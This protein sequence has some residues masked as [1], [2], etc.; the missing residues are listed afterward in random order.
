MVPRPRQRPARSDGVP[1]I[2]HAAERA[3]QKRHGQGRRRD[4]AQ[5]V[6]IAGRQAQVGLR[7][8]GGGGPRGHA[9][10]M[11]LPDRLRRRVVMADG[12]GIEKRGDRA[13][14]HRPV[15]PVQ[16]LLAAGHVKARIPRR[17]AQAMAQAAAAR[18]PD[19]G[20]AQRRARRRRRR[21]QARRTAATRAAR[22]PASRVRPPC[23]PASIAGARS[24]RRAPLRGGAW[25]VMRPFGWLAGCA[26]PG[27]SGSYPLGNSIAVYH[28]VKCRTRPDDGELIAFT[29]TSGISGRV[30]YSLAITAP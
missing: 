12:D 26:C 7:R 8:A 25:S 23:P 20:G 28:L 10:D 11:D 15:E 14:G 5:R 1:H 16:R 2:G 29:R 22:R 18:D 24:R 13:A 3:E 17:S 30:L 9:G 19:T 27:G 6:G 4:I 21:R